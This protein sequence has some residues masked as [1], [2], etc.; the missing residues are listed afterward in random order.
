MVV[1]QAAPGKKRWRAIPVFMREGVGFEAAAFYILTSCSDMRVWE[2]VSE[3]RPSHGAI[4]D[5][6][7]VDTGAA[8]YGKASAT[9]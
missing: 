7:L 1:G 3:V 6:V 5:G 2:T 4:K 9:F 8:Y